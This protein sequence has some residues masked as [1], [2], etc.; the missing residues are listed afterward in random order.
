MKTLQIDEQ[1]AVELYANTSDETLKKL[2]EDSFGKSFLEGTE[3]ATIKN[4]Q[5]AQAWLRD[6]A[7]VRQWYA[8]DGSSKS[9]QEG[10]Y[11]LSNI[12]TGYVS[13]VVHT[14]S[15]RAYLKLLTVMEAINGGWRPNVGDNG[16]SVYWDGEKF[17]HCIV[18]VELKDSPWV[19]ATT[20]QAKHFAKHFAQDLKNFYML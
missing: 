8:V 13:S 3:Y 10:V 7:G 15:G 2:L 18:G 1:K 6:K 11:N 16:F 9:W 19:F 20:G 4:I 14:V 17:D 5:N 12:P